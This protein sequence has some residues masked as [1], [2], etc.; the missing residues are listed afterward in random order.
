MRRSTSKLSN[1]RQRLHPVATAS[2][3]RCADARPQHRDRVA[4]KKN[5]YGVELAKIKS[6]KGVIELVRSSVE[7][8]L[9]SKGYTIAPGGT[10]VT[11]EVLSFYSDFKPNFLVPV[12]DSAAEV[13]FNLKV[14]NANGGY[15]YG[16]TY[17][18][19][20]KATD[21]LVMTPGG[22]RDAL[23]HAL[24]DVMQQ[25]DRDQVLFSALAGAPTTAASPSRASQPVTPSTLVP[26]GN[27]PSASVGPDPLPAAAPPP[28]DPSSGL[29]RSRL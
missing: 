3:S 4:T 8:E 25:L 7:G 22:A 16:H 21:V 18:A 5:G 23:E 14:T 10:V 29:S 12:A 2:S 28:I 26:A 17:S 9:R 27:S 19:T 6:T 11:A 15:V 20:G 24:T 1:R 13:S